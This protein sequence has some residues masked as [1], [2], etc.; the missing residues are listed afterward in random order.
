VSARE[1]KVERLVGRIVRDA[2]G[3][4][5]GRLSEIVAKKD[6][7][8]FVVTGYIVGP[9]AWVHRFA[10]TGLGLRMRGLGQVYRV[11]WDQ[12]DLSDP[13]QPRTTCARHELSR[14]KLP[15]RKRG[16]TRRPTHPLA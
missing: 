14:E 15:R 11:E 12:M 8:E 10:V 16:L 3:H 13:R 5:V 9:V 1:V 4:R 7:D 6:G 2:G